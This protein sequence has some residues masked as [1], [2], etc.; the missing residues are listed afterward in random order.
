M[1]DDHAKHDHAKHDHAKHDHAKH[2]HAKHA[3]HGGAGAPASDATH[4]GV[5]HHRFED[6]EAWA[7][8]FDD[9][10]R[11]AWQ[12]PDEVLA[13]LALTPGMMVADVGAGTGYFTMRMARA[14]PKGQV[15]ATDLEA[16][17]VRY[18]GERAAREKLT[19]V[20]PVRAEATNPHLPAN[21]FDRVLVV[22]V[23]H[24]L[25]DRVGYARA[26]AASLAP[27]GQ[28]VIVDFTLAASKGPPKEMRL[29]PEAII[30]DLRAA[31]LDAVV[32]PRALPEQYIVI[33]TRR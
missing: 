1:P 11:D 13:E 8:V 14:V 7:K 29:P 31:G 24:H 15:V 6:A 17:M 22:D 33:G 2:D 25:A 20:R 19:N 18:L 3:G 9:P 32:S 12:R 28:L 26:I 23:W 4:Q 21:T 5:M 30:A 10:A 16:D 27:R